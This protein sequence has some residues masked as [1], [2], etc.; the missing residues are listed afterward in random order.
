MVAHAGPMLVGFVYG[1]ESAPSVYRVENIKVDE[2]Y[3]GREIGTR[4]LQLLEQE[5]AKADYEALE[6]Y[7]DR[8]DIEAERLYLTAGFIRDLETSVVKRFTKE[9]IQPEV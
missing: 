9:V 4:I 1:E 8:S 3:H 5:A 6:A 7:T 2:S